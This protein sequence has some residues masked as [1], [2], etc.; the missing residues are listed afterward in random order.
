MYYQLEQE[1]IRYEKNLILVKIE[2]HQFGDIFPREKS[3]FVC[4]GL[5]PSFLNVFFFCLVYFT[6]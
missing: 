1:K 6:N 5:A 3:F 2:F 4:T